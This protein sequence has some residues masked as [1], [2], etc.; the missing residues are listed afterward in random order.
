MVYR[1]C[2]AGYA[3]FVVCEKHM[4]D[5]LQHGLKRTG[6]STR[7]D[8]RPADTV[9]AIEQA[10]GT[11]SVPMSADARL[12]AERLS[13]RAR[14]RTAAGAGSE[15]RWCWLPPRVWRAGPGSADGRRR[16]RPRR[17]GR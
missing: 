6:L 1:S 8:R 4:R 15:G 7:I 12:S 17:F 11:P 13:G 3:N 5:P 10:L 16:V 9:V 14:F 2:S